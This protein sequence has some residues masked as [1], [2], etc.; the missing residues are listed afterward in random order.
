MKF[1]VLLDIRRNLL[2]T[3]PHKVFFVFYRILEYS[4]RSSTLGARGFSC[5]VSG[6]GQKNPLGKL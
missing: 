1:S 2:D 6:V 5:A 4:N 3:S